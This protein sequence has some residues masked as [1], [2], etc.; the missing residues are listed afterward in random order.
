[1]LLPTNASFWR[2]EIPRVPS[3]SCSRKRGRPLPA[4]R[5][6]GGSTTRFSCSTEAHSQAT[7]TRAIISAIT[8]W[9]RSLISTTARVWTRP[10]PTSWLASCPLS[11]QPQLPWVAQELPLRLALSRD[12]RCTNSPRFGGQIFLTVLSIC[13]TSLPSIIVNQLLNLL[14]GELL[15]YIN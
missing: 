13:P 10:L 1:M 8:A 3:S 7:H 4:L 14:L 12:S 9:G 11:M 2:R 6:L 5:L 15:Q